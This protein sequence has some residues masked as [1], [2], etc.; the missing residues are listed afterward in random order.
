MVGYNRTFAEI[1]L[2][3]I[4]WNINELKKCISPSVKVM[5]IIKAD[6]YGHGAVPIMQF[7]EDNVDAYGVATIDEAIE[8]RE[9]G[10][11]KMILILGYTPKNCLKYVVKY[12]ISQAIFD[13]DSAKVLSE[14]ACKQNKTA[15]IHIKLDTGMGRIGF[16]PGKE[17][18][19]TIKAIKELPYITLEGCFTHFSKADEKELDYTREQFDKYISFTSELK[20]AGV[21]F[22]I[23]HVCNS[24]A[25]MQFSQAELDMVRFGVASYGLYPSEDIE[26]DKVMLIPAMSWKSMITHVKKVPAG[27]R[28]SYGGTYIAETERTI[29]TVSVGYA[30]GYPRAL[31]GCGRVLLHGKSAPIVG[32]VCMD[33][34]MIDVTDIPNVKVEDNVTLIGREGNECITVEELSEPGNSF[35]YE[36]VCDVGNRVTRKYVRWDTNSR[37]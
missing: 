15:R 13:Y 1:N 3:N 17:S 23:R 8:L 7:L 31:S 19:D 36:F 27:S 6:G 18:I 10:C 29:A 4:L 32:R 22:D 25:V 28:I 35:N 14:E 33:Q 26:K 24:A 16:V 30:D 21:E 34:F 37:V 5:F 11:S 20:E 12:D 2:N 9:H